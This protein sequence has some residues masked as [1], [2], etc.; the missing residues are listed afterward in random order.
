VL[1]QTPGGGAF[2]VETLTDPRGFAGRDG[3]F[4]F[5]PDGVAQRALAVLRVE[6]HGAEVISEAPTSFESR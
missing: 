4:R 1:A 2:D 5:Q 6:R 3:I